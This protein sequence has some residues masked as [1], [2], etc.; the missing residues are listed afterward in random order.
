MTSLRLTGS[1]K[2]F[3]VY[4]TDGRL[5]KQQRLQLQIPGSFCNDPVFSY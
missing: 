5:P 2:G 1:Q 4:D 3:L